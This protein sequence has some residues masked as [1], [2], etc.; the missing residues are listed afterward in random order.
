MGGD[1]RLRRRVPEIDRFEGDDVQVIGISVDHPFALKAWSQAQG[2]D[3][4]TYFRGLGTPVRTVIAC[5]ILL[6]EIF[7]AS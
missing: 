2:F 6:P 3:F 1:T 4:P 5:F 7:S